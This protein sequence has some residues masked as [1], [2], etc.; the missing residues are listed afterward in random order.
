MADQLTEQVEFKKDMDSLDLSIFMNDSGIP[1]E[2]SA[3]FDGK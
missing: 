1:S 2:M 3:I